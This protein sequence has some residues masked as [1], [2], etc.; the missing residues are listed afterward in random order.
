MTRRGACPDLFAPM[1][2]A[3]GL[4]ARVKP[5]A[6]LLAAPAARALAEA[7]AR[8]GN[9]AIELTARGS[10]QFR[11]LTP[12]SLLPF[13]EIVLALGLAAADPAAERRRRVLACALHPAAA[14]LPLAIEAT[15]CADATLDT[16]PVKF[17]IR[18]EG[19]GLLPLAG[20]GADIL[21]RL[22]GETAHIAADGVAW[23]CAVADAPALLATL[24]RA[25]AGPEASSLR[26]RALIRHQPERRAAPPIGKQAEGLFGIGIP[27]GAI[28]PACLATL[29]TWAEESDGLLRLT[30]HRAVLLAGEVDAE[31]IAQQG[32][33]A[34]PADPRLRL[35]ACVGSPCCAAAEV[36]ARAD[37]AWF[38][39]LHPPM[40]IHLA[41]C[42]KG[43][44]RPEDAEVTLIG[45]A[46]GYDLTRAGVP[47]LAGLLREAAARALG[48]LP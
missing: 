43:C 30:P 45:R 2:A 23:S 44:A 11:G 9:G 40:P 14:A 42:A 33:I 4:L 46:G 16:L 47:T 37:A 8:Y 48:L 39:A 19:D 28:T 24:A 31:T 32:L 3:D 15:L 35:S 13:A 34:D 20:I 1:A 12:A 22:A 18:V 27:F 41:G 17:C 6:G 38:A 5:P 29:A 25:A 7:A 10:L 21:V 26:I 36:P